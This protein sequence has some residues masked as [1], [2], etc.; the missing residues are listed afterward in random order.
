MK[1]RKAEKKDLT[2]ILRI[3]DH[4]RKFMAQNGNPDQRQINIHPERELSVI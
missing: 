2:D 4:A 3:Y 1:I